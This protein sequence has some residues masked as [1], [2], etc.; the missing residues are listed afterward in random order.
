MTNQHLSLKLRTT[1]TAGDGAEALL[2]NAENQ[3]GF[4]P[5]L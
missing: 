2:E 3:L 4:V 5:S 1:G